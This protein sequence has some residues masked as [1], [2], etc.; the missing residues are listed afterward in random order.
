MTQ[1]EIL[2]RLSADGIYGVDALALLAALAQMFHED[3][4]TTEMVYELDHQQCLT[5]AGAL[6]ACDDLCDSLR[7]MVALRH[8]QVCTGALHTPFSGQTGVI[9][10]LIKDALEQASARNDKRVDLN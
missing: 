6:D 10:S 4:A 8:A 2:T 1:K 3:N 5:L 7:H 9:V